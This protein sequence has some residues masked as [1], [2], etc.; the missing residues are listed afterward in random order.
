MVA[1]PSAL[2][3][4]DAVM[5]KT[6]AMFLK[7]MDAYVCDCYDGIAV[8]LCIH[9]VLRF[10]AIMAKR[11]IPAVDR[12]W[13]ALLELLWPRFEHILELNIQSIQSTD[14]QKLGFLDTRPHY[15]RAGGGF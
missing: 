9:I 3:L 7:H 15:V 1:G 6:L 5:G 11:N 13:E 14:P 8:F 10:R 12:Y 2:E 4:F